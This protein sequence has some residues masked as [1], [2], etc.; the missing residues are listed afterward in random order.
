MAAAEAGNNA[1]RDVIFI[2]IGVLLFTAG[3]MLLKSASGSSSG[4][5]QAGTVI[6]PSDAVQT[7]V[8]SA[9]Q[10]EQASSNALSATVSSN[11]LAAILG[12][13][14]ARSALQLGLAQIKAGVQTASINAQGAAQIAGIQSQAQ[15][16]IAKTQAAAQDTQ[17][18]Y[19]TQIAAISTAGQE[20]DTNVTDTAQT[21]IAAQQAQAAATVS[22]NQTTAEVNA[23]DQA[24]SAAGEQST[25]NILSSV[26]SGVTSFLG[27]YFSSNPANTGNSYNGVAYPTA[28]TSNSVGAYLDSLGLDFG[29]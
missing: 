12:L 23:A 16:N 7:A 22:A 5:G 13:Q 11:S 10:A 25:G 24:R 3:F 20:Y 27:K 26:F 18:N 21:A 14:Q 8:I 2:I 4:A 19:A 1:T 6:L 29:G 17:A 9:D 28:N 15:E